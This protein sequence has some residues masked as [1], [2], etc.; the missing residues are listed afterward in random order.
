MKAKAS[1]KSSKIRPQDGA[2]FVPSRLELDPCPKC[3]NMSL[4]AL[5]YLAFVKKKKNIIKANNKSK[6]DLFE[7]GGRIGK[8]RHNQRTIEQTIGCFAYKINCCGSVHGKGCYLCE[9]E[10]SSI[11]MI[12]D[13]NG[14]SGDFVCSYRL[15]S[16]DY[17]QFFSRSKF[18]SVYHQL[19]FERLNEITKTY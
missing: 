16:S 2:L 15:C 9:K 8:K 1:K 10:I 13:I 14:D 18:K 6:R 17:S 7:T 4:M 5:E 12:P 19:E 11:K 3:K